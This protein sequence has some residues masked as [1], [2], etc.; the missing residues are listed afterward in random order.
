MSS[1]YLLRH[2]H[3]EANRGHI[4]CGRTESPLTDE[5][6]VRLSASQIPAVDK[7]FSSP[8]IRCVR[9]AELVGCPDPT[10][11]ESLREL[12]FG[13]WEGKTFEEMMDQCPE[14]AT[15]YLNDPLGHVFAHGESIPMLA[16]RVSAC[17]MDTLAPMLSEGSNVLV[18]SHGG[19]IRMILLLMLGL[20]L[21]HFWKFDI[22]P[23]RMSRLECSEGGS[24]FVAL[25]ELNIPLQERMT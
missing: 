18:V 3:T 10:T 7:V 5:A 8:S 4:Y 16:E 14:E 20:P 13:T 6:C 2:G 21:E 1:L 9:T 24:P 22:R 17:V 11:L 19:T 25:A 12:D 23:G 15:S